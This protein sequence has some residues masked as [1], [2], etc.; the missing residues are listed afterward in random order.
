MCLF[1][2]LFVYLEAQACGSMRVEDKGE[3]VGPF[4]STV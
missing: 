1:V 4:P 2:C 3:W